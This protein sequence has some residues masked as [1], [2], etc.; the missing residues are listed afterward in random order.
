M[1]SSPETPYKAASHF[2]CMVLLFTTAVHDTAAVTASASGLG[3]HRSLP[4][5]PDIKQQHNCRVAGKQRSSQSI[6]SVWGLSV[7]EVGLFRLC[8]HFEWLLSTTFVDSI[9][10][11]PL[12][13]WV[14][15]RQ[16]RQGGQVLGVGRGSAGSCP[17]ASADCQLHAH[18]QD[19]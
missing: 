10:C 1:Q 11:C 3:F 19:D 5:S 9:G 12:L 2:L 6:C 17:G 15:Q 8:C 18:P 13:Q 7:L 16:C 4:H 14:C